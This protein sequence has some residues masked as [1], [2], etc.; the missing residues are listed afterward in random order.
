MPW[1][2]QSVTVSQ[3]IEGRWAV[4][5]HLYLLASSRAMPSPSITKTCSPPHSMPLLALV[6]AHDP[7]STMWGG[8]GWPA[9]AAGPQPFLLFHPPS[10]SSITHSL[11]SITGSGLKSMPNGCRQHLLV[12]CLGPVKRQ[13]A[14]ASGRSS[15][16]GFSSQRHWSGWP[17]AGQAR[18]APLRLQGSQHTI[19]ETQACSLDPRGDLVV[20]S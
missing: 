14:G 13:D 5:I 11:P 15:P 17:R 20:T 16:G 6:S 4:S 18:Q 9:Q 12:R 2:H 7:P 10:L 1:S 19:R 3:F 8:G